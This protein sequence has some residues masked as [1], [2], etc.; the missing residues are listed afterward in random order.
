MRARVI[1]RRHVA[2]VATSI[3]GFY[4]AL[5]LAVVASVGRWAP[6]GLYG[7]SAALVLAAIVPFSVLLWR[8]RARPCEIDEG[9]VRV[10]RHVFRAESVTGFS[11][12]PDGHGVSVAIGSGAQ[13]TFLEVD[14][15]N[16]ARLI[17][18]AL[19]KRFPADGEL[20]LTLPRQSPSVVVTLFSVCALAL[21]VMLPPYAS[22]RD[23]L[24]PFWGGMIELAFL[25]AFL[26]IGRMRNPMK[27]RWGTAAQVEPAR[28]LDRSPIE[29]HVQRH[30]QA[31]LTAP[32]AA[33]RVRVDL[34]AQGGDSVADWLARV[35]RL[36]RAGGY[37][38]E[39]APTELLFETVRDDNAPVD[40]RLAAARLLKV[41]D[42]E[43]RI[44][45]A[46]AV[47]D[48]DI[49]ARIL[50]VTDDDPEGALDAVGPLFRAR[51]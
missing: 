19:K 39:A 17:A 28:A 47:T 13:T 37:R 21:A 41:R 31:R 2:T 1:Q 44:R 27:L 22:F 35:D 9:V 25:L 51:N 33:P 42:G 43:D 15:M 23:A 3:V 48:A 8:P 11:V 30:A 5:V 10:G 20:H 38:G 12:A 18:T 14:T 46:D 40:V 4:G 45:I 29:R 6:A 32:P 26:A 34:L 36:D 50:A 24:A 7:A 49:R 16:D